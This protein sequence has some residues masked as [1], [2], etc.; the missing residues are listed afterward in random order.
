MK[1]KCR[2][3]LLKSIEV[4][5][6]DFKAKYNRLQINNYMLI[7]FIVMKCSQGLAKSNMT[8]TP[9][10]NGELHKISILYC[11][12]ANPE[13]YHEDSPMISPFGPTK[14]MYLSRT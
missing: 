13:H 8:F 6:K 7:S 5:H 1:K 4:T 9:S 14:K 12:N 11:R 10:Q 3:A 2:T